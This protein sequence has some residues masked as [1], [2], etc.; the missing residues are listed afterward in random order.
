MKK[1]SELPE[2]VRNIKQPDGLVLA[3]DYK[4]QVVPE[5]EGNIEALKLIN[6]EKEGLT[7]Y[8]YLNRTFYSFQ[9]QF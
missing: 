4:Y 2:F 8:K 6:L 3:S 9:I 7:E 5:L 1:T